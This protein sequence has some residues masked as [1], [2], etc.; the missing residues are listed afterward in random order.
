[1]T[2]PLIWL[3]KLS[4][5]EKGI[6]D[7]VTIVMK[8]FMGILIYK[9]RK[10]NNILI[11]RIRLTIWLPRENGEEMQI[12]HELRVSMEEYEKA[13]QETQRKGK[14]EGK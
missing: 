2:N 11:P 5:Q 6:S 7:R 4:R 10:E 8:D 3:T 9:V 14:N 13:F 1:M 12:E